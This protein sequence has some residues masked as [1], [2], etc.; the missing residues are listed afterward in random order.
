MSS[1]RDNASPRGLARDTSRRCGCPGCLPQAAPGAGP[2]GEHG[3]AGAEGGA[4]WAVAPP[5]GG[6]T[7]RQPKGGAQGRGSP[8]LRPRRVGAS[9]RRAVLGS[10]VPA[11][12]PRLLTAPPRPPSCPRADSHGGRGGDQAGSGCAAA[13][14]PTQVSE[15]WLWPRLSIPDAEAPCVGSGVQ[16]PPRG[17]RESPVIRPVRRPTRG[18]P[19]SGGAGRRVP[20]CGV[21][22]SALRGNCVG[23]PAGPSRGASE[24]RADLLGG[25][26]PSLQPH[27]RRVRAESRPGV[28]PVAEPG[29]WS[30]GVALRFPIY[31][32]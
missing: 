24:L 25:A 4:S 23:R 21:S 26:G 19:R 8:L 12:W 20:R 5:R 17:A 6:A 1:R 14:L 10:W 32:E 30:V 29:V 22:R 7:P 11:G 13:A 18:P 27:A 31:A 2:P 15:L 9:E 3:S 16:G 28:G